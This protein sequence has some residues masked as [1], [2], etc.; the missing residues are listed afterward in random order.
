[1]QEKETDLA[2]FFPY[3]QKRL[4]GYAHHVHAQKWQEKQFKQNLAT[5]AP[6]EVVMVMDFSMN[7]TFRS[8]VE[9]QAQFFNYTPCSLFNVGKLCAQSCPGQSCDSRSP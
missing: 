1:M 8:P 3:F 9:V 5:F 2:N 6:G 4:R 7:Y